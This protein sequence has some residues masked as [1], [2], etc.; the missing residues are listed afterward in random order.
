M[1]LWYPLQVFYISAGPPCSSFSLLKLASH[2]EKLTSR[3][4]SC[5]RVSRW[6]LPTVTYLA[7]W[8]LACGVSACSLLSTY[9]THRW[10]CCRICMPL[11]CTAVTVQSVQE[12][13]VLE[14]NIM[15]SVLQIRVCAVVT[16][17]LNCWMS[18]I[19]AASFR[20][21][22]C[23]YFTALMCAA[24]CLLGNAKIRRKVDASRH[25]PIITTHR[26]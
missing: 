25:L 3:K 20:N 2:A 23:R 1:H 9:N 6:R 26:V 11:L 13:R 19:T 18:W 15:R 4:R 10:N 14:I 12:R 24:C 17:R 7:Y 22:S 8:Q 21:D 16:D 5:Y